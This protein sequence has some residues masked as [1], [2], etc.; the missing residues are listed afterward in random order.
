MSHLAI[1]VHWRGP[2]AQEDVVSTELG[3]GLYMFAGKRP[4]ERSE[5][6]QYCGITEGLFRNRFSQHHKIF[7][8]T[9][10]LTIWLGQIS[11]PEDFTR[12]HLET[13]EKIVVYFWQPN[14]NERKKVSL[15]RPT[16]LISHWFKYDGMVRFNQKEIY[17]DLPDVLCWDGQYWRTGNLCVW[18]H[19]I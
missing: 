13:A 5:Q 19:D 7:E 4:Y 15:P 9:R 12:T 2:F 8:I 16:T 6:I 14:L 17:R 10:D 3:N 11:V 1:T 18:E